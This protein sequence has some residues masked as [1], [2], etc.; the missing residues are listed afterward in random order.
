MEGMILVL[1]VLLA[2]ALLLAGSGSSKAAP[3]WREVSTSSDESTVRYRDRNGQLK[4][5]R[6]GCNGCIQIRAEQ[7]QREGC[8]VEEVELGRRNSGQL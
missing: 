3:T 5:E 2:L 6:D 1:L 7:L 8:T 4:T